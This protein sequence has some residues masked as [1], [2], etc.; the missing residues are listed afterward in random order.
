MAT[1]FSVALASAPGC[2]PTEAAPATTSIGG[3]STSAAGAGIAPPAGAAGTLS[4]VDGGAAGTT[5]DGGASAVSGRGAGGDNAGGDSAGGGSA[6]GG[7]AAGGTGGNGGAQALGGDANAGGAVAS[8]PL[9]PA[10]LRKCTA[11]SPIVCQL[12]APN[13]NWDV[14]IDLG[15][16][17]MAGNTRVAAE[18]RH[19]YGDARATAAGAHAVLNFTANVRLEQHDGGQSAPANVLDLVIDGS[20]PQLRGIGLR[21]A[22]HAI[23]LFVAGDSTLCDW[24]GT[25]TSAVNDDETGWAQALAQYFAPGVAVANYAD[26]GET[27]DSFYT[28]FFPAAR[29]AMKAGDYLFVQFG[30]NDQKDATAVANYKSNLLK[31][32]Q[33]ARAKQVTPVLFTP[34]SRSTGTD[35]D[36]GFMGLDQEVRDLAAAE[37]VA[38]VDLTLLSRNYYK[39]VADKKAVFADSGTHLSSVGATAVAGLVAQALKVSDLPL[40][41]FVR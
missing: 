18:T 7:S 28:K 35:A 10:L 13:G 41:A 2:S 37:K 26:S 31:Y 12:D 15:S 24:V 39:T 11:K 25:N 34:V 4:N 32:V 27:A 22:P 33:D 30:H 5:A 16:D 9:D 38:Y 29:N 17:T 1:V 40:K 21:A 36:P 3:A 6:A 19:Y 23:T 20:A 14:T 8:V